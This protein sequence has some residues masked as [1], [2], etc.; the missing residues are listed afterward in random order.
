MRFR[1]AFSWD[2]DIEHRAVASGCK[3]L[4]PVDREYYEKKRPLPFDPERKMEE[5]ESLKADIAATIG[6]ADPLGAILHRNCCQYQ[7]V[8]RM[9][10]ARGTP[11]FYKYSCELYG[12]AKD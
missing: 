3:E 1:E 7:D 10:A 8:L 6:A 12:S 9:L 2:D 11:D 5:L 4:P